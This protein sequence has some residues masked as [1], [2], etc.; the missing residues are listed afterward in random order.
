MNTTKSQEDIHEELKDVAKSKS[1]KFGLIMAGAVVLA[2]VMVYVSGQ[3]TNTTALLIPE[4]ILVASVFISNILFKKNMNNVS[5]FA[6]L[7]G[8]GFKTTCLICIFIILWTFA[9]IHI[10]PEIKVIDVEVA[11]NLMTKEGYTPEELQEAL[12]LYADNKIYY[13]GKIMNIFKLDFMLGILTALFSAMLFRSR[14][15]N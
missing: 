12:N 14:S 8:N 7:F 3:Y 15:A 2:H 10:F 6:E 9:S 5:F 4:I 11:K 1:T 13:L